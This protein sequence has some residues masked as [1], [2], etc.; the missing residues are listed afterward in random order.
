MS[1]KGFGAAL[2]RW[3]IHSSV[4]HLR[5]DPA[6]TPG[7]LVELIDR[8]VDGPLRYPLEWDD[9]ISW[10]SSSPAVE[11]VRRKLCEHERWL[12][13][14]SVKLREA[15]ANVAIEERNRLAALLGRS[16]RPLLP[17]SAYP[18]D[19][20]G[21]QRRRRNAFPF[22]TRMLAIANLCALVACAIIAAM[23]V[24]GA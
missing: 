21:E 13:S 19:P 9:F 23:L 8:F 22:S 5:L 11:T 17:S 6:A 16:V 14:R 24:R 2:R 10:E 7:E 15:Y 1:V 20:F 18:F 4:V 3:L 12:F